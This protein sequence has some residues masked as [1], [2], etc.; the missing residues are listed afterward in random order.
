MP[1]RTQ[2]ISY[3]DVVKSCD[4]D[5][6][7]GHVD[8]AVER[9]AKLKI[10]GVPREFRLRLSVICRRAGIAET[11]LRLLG[12]LVR[13]EKG[14]STLEE[15]V[16]YAALL[17]QVGL[18][19]EALE[20]LVEADRKGLA[21]ASLVRGF[22]DIRIWDYESSLQCFERFLSLQPTPYLEEVA[23]VNLAAALVA[24][25]RWDRALVEIE[26]NLKRA[27]QNGNARLIGNCLEL[28]ARVFLAQG[29]FEL[30][31]KDLEEAVTISSPGS[32]DRLFIEKW[33]AV[34]SSQETGRIE[35]LDQ[36]K[37][38]A[39]ELE[40]WDTVREA[41][42][43]ACK[44]RFEQKRFD[45]L[46]FGSPLKGYRERILREVEG[47]PSP[48]YFFGGEPTRVF[49]LASGRMQG[50]EKINAGKKIHQTLSVICRDFY[51][52][53]KLGQV[54]AQIYPNEYFDIFS[55]PTRVHSTIKR[56]R[57]WLVEAEIPATIRL[58]SGGY[59]LEI[60]GPFAFRME[61]EGERVDPS[62]VFW[63]KL[64]SAFPTDKAFTVQMACR[65]LDIPKTTFLRLIKPMVKDGR[66]QVLNVG[67]ATRYK[68]AE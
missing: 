18:V 40:H 48:V 68:I 57:D 8:A 32:F 55:S 42:L 25:A 64:K 62:S 46:Y 51:A 37:L 61:L 5:L 2:K 41:D 31:R 16:E 22:C 47:P 17:A 59:L 7:A 23:R 1:S 66:L 21:M 10:A 60:H 58:V 19:N 56:C 38:K 28:R 15:K 45:H 20:I 44:I 24:T 9:I 12:R 63:L 36:L 6:K 13:S 27:R 26:G 54:F 3:L 65:E 49:D 67:R 50:D 43:F 52:P 34:L 30:C 11:G 14:E 35:A 33:N 4:A 29:K 53:V 39:R